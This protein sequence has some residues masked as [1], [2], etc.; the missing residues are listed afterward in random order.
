MLIDQVAAT[1]L[2][3]TAEFLASFDKAT[4]DL[5][6]TLALGK[7]DGV[8][9]LRDVQLKEVGCGKVHFA[10]GA[11]IAV[12]LSVVCLIFEVGREGQRL[13]GWE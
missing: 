12:S 13:V 6:A 3:I 10:F 9:V 8:V 2:P 11:A 5:L 1:F 7:G 4:E